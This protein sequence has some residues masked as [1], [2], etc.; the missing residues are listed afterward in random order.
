[1]ECVG[2]PQG[3]VARIKDERADP[4]P[5]RVLAPLGDD[6]GKGAGGL[7]LGVQRQGPVRGAAENPSEFRYSDLGNSAVQ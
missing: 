6:D 3:Y 2:S 5:G 4:G 1:M 7:S